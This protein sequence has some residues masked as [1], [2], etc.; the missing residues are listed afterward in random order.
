MTQLAELREIATDNDHKAKEAEKQST[1]SR[2]KASRYQGDV[3]TLKSQRKAR[4]TFEDIGKGLLKDLEERSESDEYL[5]S[6]LHRYSERMAAYGERE[7]K[8]KQV[9]QGLQRSYDA[10][11]AHLNQKY[12]EEGK[13]NS[14]KAGHEQLLE[15]RSK[16]IREI[17]S[18]HSIRGYDHELDDDEMDAFMKKISNM[19]RERKSSVDKVRNETEAEVQ[20]VQHALDRLRER[21]SGL[22]QNRK[23]TKE[24]TSTTD[25]RIESSRSSLKKLRVD[26]GGA[27]LLQSTIQELDAQLKRAKG[28]LTAMSQN[29]AGQ[30]E[31]TELRSSED[32][33][34]R[35]AKDLAQVTSNAGELARLDHL[36][37]ELSNSQ[38]RLETMKGA[39]RERLR[40]LV[41]QDWSPSNIQSKYQNVI[42]SKETEFQE[43]KTLR[44]GVSRRSEQIGDRLRSL[45]A[46]LNK[47]EK[48]QEQCV[49]DIKNKVD[50]EPEGYLQILQECQ[51]NRDVLKG[52]SDGFAAEQEFFARCLETANKDGKCRICERSFHKIDEKAKFVQKMKGLL[53]KQHEEIE[54]DLQRGENELRRAKDASPS[55]TTWLRLHRTE[56]PRLRGEIK[57]IEVERNN[58]LAQLDEYDQIVTNRGSAKA[59][60]DTLSDPVKTIHDYNQQVQRF[61]AESQELAEKQNEAGL[62]RTVEDV[63]HELEIASERSEQLRASITKLKDEKEAARSRVK[64]LELDLS[65]A[66]NK[67]ITNNHDLEKKAD[68][69]RQIEDLQRDSEETREA[70]KQ[71][72]LEITGLEPLIGEE[73]MKLADVKQRGFNE[74]NS[75]QEKATRLLEGVNQ[76]EITSQQIRAYVDD[77]GPAKLTGCRREIERL[78][79]EKKHLQ[80]E[81]TQITRELN[82]IQK[83]LQN[84][85]DNRRNTEDNIKYRLNRQKLE[86][87]ES[88]IASLEAA[89]AE[90]D[91]GRHAR[92]YQYLDQ[93]RQKFRDTAERARASMTAKDEALQGLID[94]FDQFYKDAAKDFKKSHITV[95]V[96][97]AFLLRPVQRANAHVDDQSRNGRPEPIRYGIGQVRL[98]FRDSW[99]SSGWNMLTFSQGHHEV[100]R[101]QDGRDQSNYR[102]TLAKDVSRHG[103]RLDTDPIR[104]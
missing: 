86:D 63:Q 65:N 61:E 67:L 68:I 82:K 97:L 5:Q 56:L 103:R 32:K 64:D 43:A 55:H 27:A 16:T 48:E 102:G 39:H 93:Q 87:I 71:L 20:R 52:D 91:L 14:D 74:E 47:G 22:I 101:H 46:E 45:R 28:D 38:R 89:N 30:T 23:S 41:D 75:L 51:E 2:A 12:R 100:P 85:K 53:A 84:Q 60:M 6:E 79:Q 1:Q 94:E 81:Q 98:P 88:E 29:G 76:L 70:A 21:K 37:K 17:A 72:G 19:S 13:H 24:R 7:Q 33:Q 26:E 35:L 90:A 80:N 99:R 62:S 83:E 58:V 73:E 69:E 18:R 44:D 10:A 4:E 36:R 31:D 66:R 11:D 50:V 57:N 92:E 42:Q 59:E 3:E 34:K 49:Q 104:Q 8:Q 77:G 40:K 95:E 78:E 25:R 9:Y 96:I 54:N 15:T